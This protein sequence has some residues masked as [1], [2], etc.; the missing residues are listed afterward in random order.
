MEL[1]ACAGA[2]LG[3]VVR[4]VSI[5]ARSPTRQTPLAAAAAQL[6]AALLRD[7]VLVFAPE[8]SSTASDSGTLSEDELVE[9][10]RVFDVPLPQV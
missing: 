6:R 1:L 10:F 2:R 8:C 5:S 7:K 3:A 4:G 9:F